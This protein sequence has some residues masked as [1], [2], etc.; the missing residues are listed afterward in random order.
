MNPYIKLAHHS[1]LSKYL[2]GEKIYPINIE[3]SPTDKCNAKCEWCF[4]SGTDHEEE[5]APSIMFSLINE[6]KGMNVKAVTWSGGGEPS[7]HKYLPEFIEAIPLEIDQGL[8]TNGISVNYNPQDLD[9]IRVSKTDKPW[10]I[11]SLEKIRRCKKVGMC[12]NYTGYD[13]SI[14]EDIR[15]ANDLQFDYVQ[16]RPALKTNGEK[17]KYGVPQIANIGAKIIVSDY[18]FFESDQKRT[19]TKCEG[20]HFVPFIWAN[21]DV[22]ACAYHRGNKKYNLGNVYNMPFH[23][24]MRNAPDLVKVADDCQVC[25]KNHEI[26]KFIHD[27]KGLEDINFV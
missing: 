12:I 20:Y 18:K 6:L 17:V 13:E 14:L 4:Y 16:I 2:N 8:F 9:W 22:D 26:N 11:K 10:N 25:C 24:I 15:I 7:L 3:I 5:I 23:E 21:G 1:R 19:Y 27:L